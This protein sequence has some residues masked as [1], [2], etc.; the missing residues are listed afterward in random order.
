[1]SPSVTELHN[2]Y[3]NFIGTTGSTNL[4]E[5][6]MI[7]FIEAV[8]S[9][10]VADPSRRIYGRPAGGT[11]QR[12]IAHTFA[13]GGNAIFKFR[14]NATCI[15]VYSLSGKKVEALIRDKGRSVD[16]S[17]LPLGVYLLKTAR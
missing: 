4:F 12:I 5:I 9:V 1:M 2:L 15:G 7:R 6:D 8:P 14:D 3:V 11:S 10:G 16:M 17:K 13:A